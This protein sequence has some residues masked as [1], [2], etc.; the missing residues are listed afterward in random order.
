MTRFILRRIAQSALVIWGVCTIV[1]FLMH[2]SG[3]PVQLL[4]PTD[5]SDEEIARVR[6]QLQLDRPLT[7]Q[8]VN[9]LSRLIQGDLGQSLRHRRP[10]L[11]LLA[12]RVPATLQLTVG[13]L[14][15]CLLVAL[16]LGTLS[17]LKRDS[18][19]DTISSFVALLGQCVPTFW[20]GIVL[21]MIF[22]VQ[23]QVVPVMG[24]GTLAHLIAPSITLGAYSAALATRMVR[25]SLLDVLDQE[26]VRTARSK[27]LT[28]WAI[29][30]RHVAPIAAMPVVTVISLQIG[31]LLSGAIVTETVFNYPGM[32]LLVVQAIFG[33][34]FTLVQGFVILLSIVIVSINLLV[35]IIYSVLDPRV[36][37]Q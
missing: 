30:V 35:D 28:E 36:R 13:A 19:I 3:D 33:R 29:I 22:A 32:G 31:Y 9:Y 5:A 37:F 27:G 6:S 17:A 11:E 12:E 21:I 8:Y 25:S 2:A 4:L 34:D 20:L 15:V 14:L 10:A 23:L 7:E 18:T 24:A 26:Y 1:F 16:P